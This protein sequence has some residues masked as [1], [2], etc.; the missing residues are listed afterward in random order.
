[1]NNDK[2]DEMKKM[3][4]LGGHFDGHDG[5]APVQCGTYCPMEDS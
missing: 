3:H 4:L 5:N 2:N 1:M